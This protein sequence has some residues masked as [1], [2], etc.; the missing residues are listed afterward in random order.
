MFRL[1]LYRFLRQ[2]FYKV[3]PARFAVMRKAALLI[4]FLILFVAFVPLVLALPEQCTFPVSLSCLD[5]NVAANSLTLTLQNGAGRDM[6]ITKISAASDGF[7][8]NAAVSNLGCGCTYSPSKPTELN[9]G[10]IVTFSLDSPDAGC[11]NWCNARDTGRQ[12]NTYNI[13][14]FYFWQDSPSVSHVLQGEA[15]VPT[16]E[17]SKFLAGQKII[18]SRLKIILRALITMPIFYILGA[19]LIDRRVKKKNKP[20]WIWLLTGLALVALY[21]IYRILNYNAPYGLTC[22]SFGFQQTWAFIILI[23]SP[24]LLGI[25]ILHVLRPKWL[26]PD[27]LNM[28]T[29]LLVGLGLIGMYIGVFT[30]GGCL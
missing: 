9:N 17:Y 2:K 24:F 6:S 1:K 13:T 15:L 18:L 25:T 22:E 14:V 29:G 11:V 10:Q 5:Y 7:G 8:G 21:G 19:W 20:L 16:P 3:K 30:V 12:K 4:V 28:L 26:P 27:I 23:F